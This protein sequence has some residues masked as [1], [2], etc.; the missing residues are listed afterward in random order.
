MIKWKDV[1]RIFKLCSLLPFMKNWRLVNCYNHSGIINNPI[2]MSNSFFGQL[3]VSRGQSFSKCLI[4]IWCKD[5]SFLCNLQ[6]CNPNNVG[7]LPHLTV[8]LR[9]LDILNLWFPRPNN[10]YNFMLLMDWFKFS[11]VAT[12]LLKS[13]YNMTQS[14][15]HL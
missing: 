14:I 7:T 1:W 9:E 6:K 2:L 3:R 8:M 12:M 11:L 4:L 10:F 13:I 15:R 5:F